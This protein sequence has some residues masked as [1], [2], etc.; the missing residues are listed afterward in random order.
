METGQRVAATP[1][2]FRISRLFS[3][4]HLWVYERLPAVPSD[5][6]EQGQ[7]PSDSAGAET[8]AD[9]TEAGQGDEPAV[10][11]AVRVE[12]QA[13]LGIARLDDAAEEVAVDA[14]HAL[15]VAVDRTPPAG[16]VTFGNH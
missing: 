13:D 15:G 1:V 8:E 9:Q 6:P 2:A 16:M 3:N 14:I 10:Q 11:E 12:L 5:L 7:V 4:L